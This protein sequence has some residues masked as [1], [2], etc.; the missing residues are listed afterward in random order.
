MMRITDTATQSPSNPEGKT[1]E[2]VQALPV[3]KG[4]R[5]IP[6]PQPSG[7]SYAVRLLA[8]TSTV[9][10]SAIL[11]GQGLWQP[12][13]NAAR[14][15]TSEDVVVRNSLPALRDRVSVTTLQAAAMSP[16][17][18]L[19]A[20]INAT[21]PNQ[22]E[23]S[24]ALPTIR[25]SRG[26]GNVGQP[27]L[28]AALP[29]PTLPPP[30]TSPPIAVEP[31]SPAPKLSSMDQADQTA[32]VIA[33]LLEVPKPRALETQ[34]LEQPATI[35]PRTKA[36]TEIASALNPSQIALTGGRDTSEQAAPTGLPVPAAT[37][38]QLASAMRETAI[39]QTRTPQE[40]A[41][42]KLLTI[43]GNTRFSSKELVDAVQ[44]AIA[45]NADRLSASD[46]P[47][48]PHSAQW[49]LRQTSE[50][51][52]QFYAAHGYTNMKVDISTAAFNGAI[53][54]IRIVEDIPQTSRLSPP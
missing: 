33:A 51:I 17:E 35:S 43:T 42:F 50:A 36:P 2:S 20:P 10:V 7:T 49:E 44:K 48:V 24:T 54:E 23:P 18:S 21:R 26:F 31:S 30:Q 6:L 39:E 41:Y 46:Q 15:P 38:M 27:A 25:I 14:L 19:P 29:V 12:D 34:T 52:T 45:V 16:P 22:L 32:T 4:D 53:P 3:I 28:T 13:T 47:G 1:V 8:I 40:G 5:L 9:G 37:S 11:L